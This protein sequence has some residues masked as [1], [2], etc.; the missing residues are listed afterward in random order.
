MDVHRPVVDIGRADLAPIEQRL[1]GGG[2]AVDVDPE[3]GGARA[4]DLDGELR[5]RRVEGELHAAPAAVRVHRLLQRGRGVGEHLVGRPDERELEAA[6]AAA[7]AERVGLDRPRLDTR[8]VGEGAVE[9]GRDRLLGALALAPGAS[10]STMK[11]PLPVPVPMRA[12]TPVA[13]PL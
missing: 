13:S 4:V 8:N 3:I 9:L 10:V 7:D 1:D 2:E 6:S 12:K 5:L 11:A